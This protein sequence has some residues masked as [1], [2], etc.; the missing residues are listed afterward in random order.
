MKPLHLSVERSQARPLDDSLCWLSSNL[1]G[2]TGSNGH[3]MVNLMTTPRILAAMTVN[4]LI[5][6][7]PAIASGELMTEMRTFEEYHRE[8]AAPFVRRLAEFSESMDGSDCVGDLR[9]QLNLIDR[10]VGELLHCFDTTRDRGFHDALDSI[11]GRLSGSVQPQLLST[12]T[13]VEEL[14]SSYVPKCR[15]ILIQPGEHET[16]AA[17]LVRAKLRAASKYCASTFALSKPIDGEQAACLARLCAVLPFI[18]VK[19]ADWADTDI[20]ALPDWVQLPRYT[21]VLEQLALGV[22]RPRTAYVC[23]VHASKRI[24]SART[25]VWSYTDYLLQAVSDLNEASKY[26]AA[27]CCLQEGIRTATANSQKSNEIE[28]RL[29]L[30]STL[31]AMGHP[32]PAAEQTHLVM[33]SSLEPEE[34]G[35]VAVQRLFYLYGARQMDLVIK[36]NEIRLADPRCRP[37]LRSL[38][39]IEWLTRRH[40][41]DAEA[42][43][44]VMGEFL[45]KFPLDARA[46]DMYVAQALDAMALG[47]LDESIRL[48]EYVERNFPACGN[49][50][51]VRRL[52]RQL[53]DVNV[54]K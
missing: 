6:M 32:M 9:E 28:L 14:Y 49:I 27:I 21:K 12:V 5:V 54:G 37:Y 51:D 24:E 4:A 35:R 50:G 25:P 13:V 42:A 43:R 2:T 19:D 38:L 22:G 52:R 1:N 40:V 34:Y 47:E 20:A 29:L 53:R 31:N 30:A 44:H 45:A 46:A 15:A 39:Y 33:A 17:A 36:E 10:L 7:W 18:L 48:L 8:V 26:T 23:Y 11:E 3:A 41:G 16:K